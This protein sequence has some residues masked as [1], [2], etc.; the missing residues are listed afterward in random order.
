[1]GQAS[2]NGIGGVMVYCK[3]IGAW[4]VRSKIAASTHNLGGCVSGNFERQRLLTAHAIQR[5]REKKRFDFVV[6]LLLLYGVLCG[7]V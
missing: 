3:V 6:P 5:K 1:M 7:T 4:A 2:R